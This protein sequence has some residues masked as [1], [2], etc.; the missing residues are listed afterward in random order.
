MP[1]TTRLL[2]AH[3]VAHLKLLEHAQRYATN[4]SVLTDFNRRGD[5]VFRF[6][7]TVRK[8]NGA[9][10]NKFARVVNCKAFP[11]LL[12]EL[13]VCLFI[14]GAGAYL[15]TENPNLGFL[16]RD[17]KVGDFLAT[18][19]VFRQLR[20]AFCTIYNAIL[21]IQIVFPAVEQV[22]ALLNIPTE[23][24]RKMEECTAS[25]TAATE[26]WRVAQKQCF[27]EEDKA[28]FESRHITRA[29]DRV[30]IAL[31]DVTF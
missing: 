31:K 1:K 29:L 10:V 26:S 14:I 2:D 15:I 5:D 30:P 28:Y 27:S 18:F 11:D 20:K 9:A 6:E 7:A 4:V 3:N 21:Q 24:I 8:Y 22:V 23:D 13:I 17:A 19:G 25:V 12:G 16:M